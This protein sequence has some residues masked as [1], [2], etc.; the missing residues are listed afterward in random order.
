MSLSAFDKV[1]IFLAFAIV[2]A[3]LDYV[4]FD[5]GL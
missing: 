4:L 2:G 1:G 3:F 5:G